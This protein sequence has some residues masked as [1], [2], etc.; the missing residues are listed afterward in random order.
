M[1]VSGNPVKEGFSVNVL[2]RFLE[3][4]G[5]GV[6]EEALARFL[7]AAPV[8]FISRRVSGKPLEHGFRKANRG[9]FP[10]SH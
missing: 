2:T 6:S 10:E 1:S 8:F 5:A 7:E 9:W 3:S 4:A